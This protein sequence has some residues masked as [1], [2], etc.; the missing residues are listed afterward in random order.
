MDKSE[1]EKEL[2]KLNSGISKDRSKAQ[3]W[4]YSGGRI[5][6][7]VIRSDGSKS[8][9]A[10]PWDRYKHESDMS[11][12]RIVEVLNYESKLVKIA[13]EQFDV[14]SAYLPKEVMKGFYDLLLSEIPSPKQAKRNYRYLHTYFI[15]FFIQF[16]PSPVVWHRKHVPAWS[17]W[18]E[19]HKLAVSTMKC[20]IQT[21]NRFMRYLH[22]V[23][24]DHYPAI[25][26]EPFSKAMLREIKAKRPM[27]ERRFIPDE[28]HKILLLRLEPHLKALY[29]LLY[30]YGLRLSEGCYLQGMSQQIKVK[31]LHVEEQ[32]KRVDRFGSRYNGPL[33]W[34][35]PPRKTPHWFSTPNECYEHISNLILKTPNEYGRELSDAI[36]AILG[37]RYRYTP[38]DCRHTFI[39]RAIRVK[40]INDVRLAV[41]HKDISV[42]SNYLKDDRNLDDDVFR[43]T[44]S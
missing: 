34:H 18:L 31:Y 11:R 23:M 10:F 44:V 16:G 8:M 15:E 6:R 17:G 26:F 41:G 30:D 21:I 37:S 19:S 5:R 4:S 38:H 3:S 40:P 36:E 24:P 9:Q 20:I 35:H 2:S 7:R 42:L 43:P 32:L 12:I 22:K 33:K 14:K 29:C 39:T 28:H 1:I 13:R 25:V 27:K